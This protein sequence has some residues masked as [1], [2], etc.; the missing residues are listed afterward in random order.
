MKT[1]IQII[2]V[3]LVLIT[4]QPICAQP[5]S[6]DLTFGTDGIVISPL[7]IQSEQGYK[8]VVQPDG[9]ILLAGFQE[10]NNIG[11]YII[12]RYNADGSLD[13]NFGNGGFA[14]IDG[15]TDSEYAYDMVLQDD[16][17]V[18]LGGSA[19]N[20]YTTVDDFALLRLNAD[21]SPDNTFGTS[22]IVMTDINGE[23]DNAFSMAL[24]DDGKILLAGHTYISGKRN[25]CVVRYNTDGSLDA[26]F[27]SGGIAM[28]SIGCITD[29]TRDIGLQQD[30]KIVICGYINDGADDHTFVCRF[31]ADGT[32]DQSFANN[33]IA[34]LDIGGNDDKL[35]ALC[36]L[37][38]GKILVGGYTRNSSNENDYLM[39]RY[40]T[41]GSLD[42]S[43]GSNGIKMHNFNSTDIII[44]MI[45]QADGKIL[46]AGGAFVFELA[47]FLENGDADIGF[48]NNGIVHTNINTGSDFS[49]TLCLQD[50]G[51]IIVAGHS[52]ENSEYDFSLARY[53]AEEGGFID[54]QDVTFGA[55]NVYPNPAINN[56]TVEYQIS[57][58][59]KI[60]I[61]LHAIDGKNM[62]TLLDDQSRQAGSHTENLTLPEGLA[63]GIYLL[64]ISSSQGVVVFR[65]EVN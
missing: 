55:I 53:H 57:S 47:R 46:T 12:A 6:L 42:N 24:Q 16:G 39:I 14:V 28:T 64:Q 58:H 38:G 30:G 49:Q 23:F 8:V 32:L 17:K 37:P 50:D 62:A 18:L 11:D 31:N 25:A 35:W 65:L 63:T 21:G 56:I 36:I 45:L 33:G 22:G 27:G 9:K 40:L 15:G 4:I 60:S 61:G 10:E 2:T 59:E 19:Y 1:F 5:G 44:D 54:D 48:G 26:A 52:K 41:D 43:F 20:Q 7:T 3:V 51:K 34:T 29:R 13:N